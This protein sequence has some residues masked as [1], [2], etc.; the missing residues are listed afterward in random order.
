MVP[1]SNKYIDNLKDKFSNVRIYRP[2]LW[3]YTYELTDFIAANTPD[4]G[5]VAPLSWYYGNLIRSFIADRP[6][7]DQEILKDS[8][9]LIF[10]LLFEPDIA[11]CF[12]G[13][14]GLIR[15]TRE[16]VEACLPISN[17]VMTLADIMANVTYYYKEADDAIIK[18]FA[19]FEITD[20]LNHT[21]AAKL[22]DELNMVYEKSKFFSFDF[23]L[24]NN[25]T[26][27]L[28]FDLVKD[29]LLHYD[30]PARDLN[31]SQYCTTLASANSAG[32][33]QMIYL[34]PNVPGI[35]QGFEEDGKYSESI[36]MAA[37]FLTNAI[38][39]YNDSCK[40]IRDYLSSKSY[41]RNFDN[42]YDDTEIAKLRE[43]YAIMI[44]KKII[45]NDGARKFY[46]GIDYKSIKEILPEY[47]GI[48]FRVYASLDEAFI[49]NDY[50]R[51][52]KVLYQEEKIEENVR[53]K[54]LRKKEKIVY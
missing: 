6:E 23:Y 22:M 48:N 13:N 49:I 43:A 24:A 27:L 3:D 33:M 51:I 16:S 54:Q 53:T 2:G 8:L 40:K 19:G 34:N 14:L 31:I 15:F 44:T 30:I 12:I 20:N 42:I 46:V 36:I 38:K 39:C 50:N 52:V 29:E 10:S 7:L 28:Q 21:V 5:V 45:C 41:I 17:S 25:M 18:S 9:S 4:Y 1:A 47:A 35:K 26:E 32:N 37:N 11:L